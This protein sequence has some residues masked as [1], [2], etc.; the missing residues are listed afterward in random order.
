MALDEQQKFKLEDFLERMK[1]YRARHTEL[2]TVYVP[3]G[4][5]LNLITRQLEAEKSTAANIKSTSTRKNVQD[6][7]ESLIRIAKTK[8]TPPNGI[9][10]F[11]GNVSQ[12]EGQDDF[13]VEAFEPPE[14]IGVRLYRCDQTFVLDP[15]FE[16]LEVK[17][18]YGLIVIERKEATIGMLV[19]K[20]IKVI[21]HVDSFVPGK[22]R[23]GGQC[24]SPDTII[25]KDN[26]ELIEIKDSHNPLLVMSENFN[27]EETEKTPIIAKWGNNKELFKIT[28]T[29]PKFEIKSSDEHMFFVRT[30]SGIEEKPLSEIKKGDFLLMPEKINLS[31]SIQEID[32]IPEI[33]QE[34]NMKKVNISNVMDENIAKVFGYYLGDGSYEVDRITF[35]EQRVEVA[36]YYKELLEKIFGITS[37]LR[38]RES[39]NYYQIRV[40]SRVISQFF[41]HYFSTKN[42]TLEG[43]IPSIVLKSPDKI[44][45]SF[46]SGFFDAE[47]Y[48]S[49]NR[50]ALGINNNF[51]ARQLQFSLLRLGIIS[52]IN[53]YDN[54]KNPY[55]DKTR[56][57]LAIDDIVSLNRFNENIGFSSKE[58]Q[59]K[60]KK[61]IESRS[62]RN[63]VR[64]IAVNGKEVARIIRNSGLNTRQFKCPDFFNNKKQMSKDVF[65]KNILDKIKD[66]ELKKRLE[67]FYLSNLIAVK[68]TNIENIGNFET[69]D[70]ETKN[71]N[72]IANGLIVH[73]SSQRFHRITE[74][75][76]KDFYRKIAEMTK[77]AF[78]N[79]KG[80][81]GILVGGPGPTKEDFLKE[82]QLATAL[83][84]KVLAVK[85]IG[86]ADEHGLEL[87]VE[88]SQ[89]ILEGQE[90]VH[91]QK[92]LEKFFNMLGKERDKTAY[93]KD[94]VMKALEYGAVDTL[95]ISRKLTKEE[96]REYEKKAQETSVK[97]EL[98]SGDIDEGVQFFNLGGI[99]AMLRFKLQ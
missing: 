35:F 67:M 48:V 60:V 87:L 76:A 56:Y 61:L 8:R 51:L 5:D 25:M 14:E 27:S 57:T 49:N 31:L 90:I 64:Q 6:A 58:K 97:I 10:L 17:E 77:D 1:S 21:Q 7:L 91:E 23:A 42:K 82:G 20:K 69:I 39:K 75:L 99:G 16:M 4:M 59:E 83:A 45:A 12:I 13:I 96:V 29:Y 68:I 62:N 81:K 95:L 26:G 79:M 19:G 15:L 24:L 22:I 86:Y 32:F 40:Y 94:A 47:G 65:K 9:C 46:I 53:E 73:N 30:S 41:N 52:S 11:A 3:K 2:I 28:T 88:V 72:F 92:L 36:E 38:F 34:F 55:S 18:L 37:D 70:I 44:L 66:S 43:V 71:H 50:V 74:G 93:G 33:K 80:L 78:F 54:R 84:D 63:K 85:D 98:I 89:D